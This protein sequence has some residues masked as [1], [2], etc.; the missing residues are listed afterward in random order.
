MPA[1]DTSTFT[2]S[3][4]KLANRET[5]H[6]QAGDRFIASAVPFGDDWH[7]VVGED[8]WVSPSTVFTSREKAELF[9]VALGRAVT[10]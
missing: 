10:A 5:L 2:V 9:L 6:L 7:V 1:T 8:G 4:G 3:I